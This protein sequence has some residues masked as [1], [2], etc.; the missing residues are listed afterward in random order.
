MT[1]LTQLV[2][3]YGFNA[4][5]LTEEDFQQEQRGYITALLL[6]NVAANKFLISW[7]TISNDAFSKHNDIFRTY[8]AFSKQPN[9]GG[10]L[11]DTRYLAPYEFSNSVVRLYDIRNRDWPIVNLLLGLIDSFISHPAHGIESILAVRIRHND[12]RREFSVMLDQVRREMWREASIQDRGVVIQ[13]L[14]DNYFS[15]IQDWI[16]KYLHQNTSKE[17]TAIFDFIPN[18]KD[19]YVLIGQ[20]EGMEGQDEIFEQ[21]KQ[22]LLHRLETQLEATRKKLSDELVPALNNAIERAV[23]LVELD[24]F[25]IGKLK[26]IEDALAA[27]TLATIERIVDWFSYPVTGGEVE[28]IT[29]SELGGAI[30]AR[31]AEEISAN[32]LIL[33]IPDNLG[34]PTITRDQAR[35]IYD[36][37]SELVINALKYSNRSKTFVRISTVRRKGFIYLRVSSLSAGEEE[38][39]TKYEAHPY[40]NIKDEIFRDFSSG[41]YKVAALAAS[42]LSE[43]AEVEVIKKAKSFHICVPLFRNETSASDM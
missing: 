15:V 32:K 1:F 9:S 43:T 13:R 39:I 35:L 25:E 16:N 8:I 17:S 34:G 26:F 33:T 23:A 42:T 29:L 10:A 2:K 14:E 30:K 7:D 19:L 36:L 4:D 11:S 20:C 5:Y 40:E 28:N 27:R 18:E 21:V 12:F 37:W 6:I 31:Y 38:G 41:L 22:F 3:K 24:G